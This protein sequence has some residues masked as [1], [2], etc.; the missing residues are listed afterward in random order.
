MENEKSGRLPIILIAGLLIIAVGVGAYFVGKSAA[1]ADGKEKAGFDRGSAQAL[2]QYQEG[3][4]KYQAIFEKGRTQGT[5]AGTAAGERAGTAAGKKVGFEQGE[6]QGEVQGEA[7]GV[8]NGAS[9]ALGGLSNWANGTFYI[10][11]GGAGPTGVP[12][13]I[14]QRKEMSPAER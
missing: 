3:K 13:A 12:F 8:T 11:S 2:A 14:T 9:A 4:P 6:K 1:D 10:V 5:A 7:Q